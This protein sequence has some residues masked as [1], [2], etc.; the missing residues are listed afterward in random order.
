ML[1][2]HLKQ[3]STSRTAR[4][5]A[6]ATGPAGAVVLALVLGCAGRT[7]LA[8]DSGSEGSG[9]SS[10]NSAE[11][12]NG[13]ADSSR[14]TG[15][16]SKQGGS[17]D[18]NASSRNSSEASSKS[19]GNASAVVAG[20]ALLV[21][22]AVGLGFAIYGWARSTQ[23]SAEERAKTSLVYLRANEFQ[24]Q[25]DLAFGAGPT[26]DDLASAAGVRRE[27]RGEFGRLLQRNRQELLGLADARRL[28][29]ER[30]LAF[31][32]RIGELMASHPTLRLDREAWL[33]AHAPGG[34][35]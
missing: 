28:T 29:P 19:S 30:A 4:L 22:S 18:V 5:V 8:T 16:S 31:L 33:A 32:A 12:S 1:E 34:A 14:S 2:S 17:S 15:D 24:L 25:Q 26:L 11:S 35:S 23:R 21:S 10:R 9:A 7:G 27:R 6:W 13:T 3:G 20:S